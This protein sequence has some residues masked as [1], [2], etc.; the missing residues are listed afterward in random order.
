AQQLFAHIGA[1]I[2]KLPQLVR[3]AD[4][5]EQANALAAQFEPSSL[6]QQQ[7][8][9]LQ[10]QA[11]LAGHRGDH[12]Q[13]LQGALS[14]LDTHSLLASADQLI[15]ATGGWLIVANRPAS[16]AVPLSLPER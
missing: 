2:G 1:F 6:P 4:L 11:Q 12:A 7:R 3:D 13:T 5:P 16:A 8:A 10:W 14:N 9:D 15:S